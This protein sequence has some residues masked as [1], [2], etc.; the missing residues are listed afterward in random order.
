M[1][2]TI[3]IATYNRPNS[4]LRLLES[5][6]QADYNGDS[7][8]LVISI[9]Y[10]KSEQHLETVAI[11]KDFEWMY[12]EKRIIEHQQNMGLKKHI[13]SCGCLTEIYPTIIMLEDDL[14]VSKQ[15]YNYTRQMLDKYGLDK[16]IAG[17]SLYTPSWIS[18]FGRPGRPF[19]PENSEYDVYFLQFAQS[20]G[21]CWT[22]SMWNDFYIWFLQN[23]EKLVVEPE[24]PSHV[25]GWP[26]SSWL[27]YHIHYVA[28][29]NK[30]FVFPYISLTTNFGDVGM[31]TEATYSSCQVHLQNKKIQYRTAD[32]LEGTKYDVFYERLDLQ[33]LPNIDNSDLCVDL[34]GAK[35]NKTKKRYWLTRTYAPYK[36]VKSFGL[37]LRPH[38][39]NISFNIQG[40]DIFLYDTSEQAQIRRKKDIN[41]TRLMYDYKVIS[42]KDSLRMLLYNLKERLKNI[43]DIYYSLLLFN[44][45]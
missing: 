4:F 39:S 26:E 33:V 15:Y 10:E 20:W 41:R 36:I 18:I 34:Y 40:D 19:I 30:Y 24:I 31:H 5:I 45:F 7:V 29:N 22:T 2:I 11:A 1:D 37:F 17:I 35:C 9:D 23:N 25:T 27:K 32:F 44:F 42:L 12:G 6:N 28:K 14:L 43:C 13:L 21:Q 8:R 3:V 38:E 16:N